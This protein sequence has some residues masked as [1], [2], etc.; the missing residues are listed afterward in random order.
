MFSLLSSRAVRAVLVGAEAGV[1]DDTVPAAR[2]PRVPPSHRILHVQA[3]VYAYFFYEYYYS[4][5]P[6]PARPGPVRSVPVRWRVDLLALV[7][8]VLKSR[9]TRVRLGRGSSACALGNYSRVDR[10]AIAAQS[11]SPEQNRC[12]DRSIH[13]SDSIGARRNWLCR[14]RRQRQRQA[15][16]RCEKHLPLQSEKQLRH[17]P[18]HRSS[19]D[20]LISTRLVS[21]RRIALL[22]VASRPCHLL[23]S[24]GMGVR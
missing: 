22:R 7:I 14:S 20:S 15:V 9:C 11:S 18:F 12:I 8:L 10:I 2:Q 5:H 17:R 4:T 13:R 19:P 1:P 24:R 6:G 16:S 3:R 23:C 21:S